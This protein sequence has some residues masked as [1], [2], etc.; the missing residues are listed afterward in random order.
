[1]LHID[2]GLTGL[3]DDDLDKMLK[4]HEATQARAI[5]DG[6]LAP[7]QASRAES[8]SRSRLALADSPK[9]SSLPTE[10]LSLPSTSQPQL[11]SGG[12]TNAYPGEMGMATSSEVT[13]A[14]P[15]FALPRDLSP[16][17]LFLAGPQSL[18][19]SPSPGVGNRFTDS[20]ALVQSKTI[21]ATKVEAACRRCI[22]ASNIAAG[23]LTAYGKHTPEQI[24]TRLAS[25]AVNL[26]GD[27][28]GMLTFIYGSVR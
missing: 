23:S 7:Q 1:M 26:M 28:S 5:L 14:S 13:L 2:S 25:S 27:L 20:L 16:S 24:I 6:G 12:S 19:F 4:A 11:T 3:D 22:D 10:T 18:G 21:F 9:C 15:S 8:A 17:I